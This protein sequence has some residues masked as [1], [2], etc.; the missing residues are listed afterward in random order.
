M[1]F[2]QIESLDYKQIDIFKSLSE[3]GL[4]HYFEPNGGLFIAESEMIIAR[5]LN[6]GIKPYAWLLDEDNYKERRLLIEK[7]PDTQIYVGNKR[8]LNQI[9]GF[10]LA[11]GI[12]CAMIRPEP[13]RINTILSKRKIAILEDVM[14]PTNVGA[15]FRSA[16]AL[17]I[18]A[19][20][21]TE[22]SSDPLYRRSARVSMGTVFSIPWIHLGDIQRY[23][24]KNSNEADKNT[25]YGKCTTDEL[26]DA[27][28]DNGFSVLGM[29]LSDNSVSIDSPKIKNLTKKAIVLGTES[30]GIKDTTLS[31]CDYIVKIPMANGVDSLNVAAASAVAFWELCKD[32]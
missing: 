10:N 22:A 14:N 1:K 23:C 16:S 18:E 6:S 30:T 32:A 9:T 19:V 21:L 7:Y 29:A 12:D 27:L 8:L 26:I 15:I 25:C 24:A 5:A 13:V 4:K 17:G 11:R 2:E 20:I 31:K 28:K 3:P